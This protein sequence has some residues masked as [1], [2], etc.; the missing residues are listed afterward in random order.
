MKK[1]QYI[2]CLIIVAL[3]G[4]CQ[5][6]DRELETDLTQDQ[7]GGSFVNVQNLLNGVYSELREGF[8]EIDNEAM[9]AS[10]TDE[11]EHTDETNTAQL[12]NQGSWNAASNPAD[13][14]GSY[15]RAIR[16]SNFFLEN[17]DSSKINLDAFKA[18]IPTLNLR[19][20][21]IRR[22]RYEARFLR[23]FFYFELVKRYRGVPLITRTL[24]EQDIASTQRSSLEQCIKFVSDECD[25]AATTLPLTYSADL[26]RATKGAA[27]ALKSRV[28]LYAASDLF[29]TPSWAGGYAKPE[30]ISLPVGDRNLRWKAAADAAKAVI[31]L[32]G[33]GYALASGYGALFNTFN[34]PEIIFTR[35]NAASNSFEIANYPIGYDRGKSGNT[36]SQDL[37]DAYEIKVDAAT[38]I[39][40]DWSNPLHAADP[41]AITGPTARDPRLRASVVINNTNFSTV[42]GITRSVQLWEG[43]RDGQPIPNASKTGYYLRKY[44]N[45]TVNLTQNTAAVHSWIHIRMAEIY[46]NYAEALNEYSPGHAD[47]AT[48]YNRTRS[49]AAMPWLPAGLTQAQVRSRIRNERRVEFAFEDH[50]AWDIRRWMIGPTT[51]G[52][53]LRGVRILQTAPGVF[54]YTPRVVE[55][56][57]FQPKMYLYPISQTELSVASGLVQNPL[58]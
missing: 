5:K 55:N 31:D 8:L 4:S 1:T 28:L 48:N 27:L 22:W 13:V 9:M 21:E 42:A 2:F 53:P 17:C 30:L 26:G 14:W 40:F 15:F 44:V 32:A 3:F 6:L 11:A 50:R 49:R 29:N 25:S 57:V 24:T 51:L 33:T 52:T 16:R 23:A 19:L 20:A 36:P 45:E 46:L 43:G 7:I 34:S 37:V 10:V 18:D 12:F 54:S 56:R 47:I 39:P 41:Y 35:R 58:W 38:A